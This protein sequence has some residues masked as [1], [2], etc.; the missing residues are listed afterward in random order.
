MN[1]VAW[2]QLNL[3]DSHLALFDIDRMPGKYIFCVDGE[4]REKEKLSLVVIGDSFSVE[5]RGTVCL[6]VMT[7]AYILQ[8]VFRRSPSNEVTQIKMQTGVYKLPFPQHSKL[9]FHNSVF[10]LASV[11]I[12]SPA[13][14]NTTIYEGDE[15][16]QQ[17]KKM[18]LEPPEDMDM[19]K[20]SGHQKTR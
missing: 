17:M 16:L 14:A 15:A 2:G 13:K 20:A 1:S 4:S 18:G 5:P 10:D 12:E 6:V 19:E 3:S 8:T 11:R 9:V 7:N